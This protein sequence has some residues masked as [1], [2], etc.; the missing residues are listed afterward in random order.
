MHK[1]NESY[2][3]DSEDSDGDQADAEPPAQ[4]EK[5]NE[6]MKSVSSGKRGR[7]K[8]PPLWSRIIDV[9]TVSQEM[10]TCFNIEDDL[11]E[12]QEEFL[13]IP[14]KS[15][16]EWKPLFQHKKYWKNL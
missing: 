9:E 14:K 12:I 11:N 3:S 4:D 8:I 2:G 13:K 6:T 15:K 16:N 5:S 7:K 1:D 10:P